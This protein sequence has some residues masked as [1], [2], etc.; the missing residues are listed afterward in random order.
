MIWDAF[1]S[2]LRPES[3]LFLVAGLVL[4]F[5]VGVLPGLST[6]TT[7]ALLLPL[8]IGL[9]PDVGLI[10]IL[11]I[12]AGAAFAGSVPAI[13]VNVPGE[14]GAAVTALDGYPMTRQGKAG[15]A[16]GISRMASTLGGVIA[17]IV[18]LFAIAPLGA[19]ALMFGAREMFVII[20]LG[21]V[22]VSTL[23]GKSVIKGLMS[24]LLGIVLGVMGPAPAS[25]QTRFAFGLVPLLDGI[26]F[27]PVL[28]GLF[29]LGQM[30]IL[31]ADSRRPAAQ[32]VSVKR[33]VR[34]E[35]KDAV[36]GAV[37]TLKRPFAVLQSTAVGIG[38][39]LVPGMG[40]GANFISYGI[41][42]RSSKDPD[43]FGK[44]APE[45]I[46]ASEAADN[47]NCASN[48]VPT[49]ALG[50]PASG[51]MA[52]IL[53]Q[54]YIQGVQ[55]GPTLLTQHGETASVAVLAI[56]V[57]SILILPLG[58]I[59]L[60]PMAQLARVPSRFLVPVVVIIALCGT[61]AYRQ[62]FTDVIIAVI[63]GLFGLLMKLH[64]YPVIPLVLGLILGPM[65]EEYLTRSLQLGRMDV[66]YLFQSPVALVLWGL[67]A[68]ALAYTITTGIRQARRARQRAAS[69]VS[70]GTYGGEV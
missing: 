61:Y 55:P 14:A 2:L 33:T 25:G 16:I 45:G 69:A 47:A 59:L 46:I 27:V 34:D 26:H 37:V 11:S 30:L 62:S 18:I 6:T 63:F 53:A 50:I 10:L 49:L 22:V 66:G 3:L 32:W 43:R 48:L 64:A 58:I 52:I 57:A 36:D 20:I 19:L 51:T 4:G 31:V 35:I 29:G 17:G 54:L 5:V 56:V 15:L 67:V 23:V 28:I 40:S 68:A 7:A 21:F 39:G 24:G 12:Y 70:A 38:L 9:D 60:S 1:L 8:S 65:A 42:K 13:L 41:A 44:G